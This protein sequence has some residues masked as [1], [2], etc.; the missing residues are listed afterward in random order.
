MCRTGGDLGQMNNNL[1]GRLR[2]HVTRFI[3]MNLNF[4]LPPHLILNGHKIAR[5]VFAATL[6]F[7]IRN[8]NR[9]RA[10]PVA[11]LSSVFFSQLQLR[12]KSTAPMAPVVNGHAKSSKM[13]SKVVCNK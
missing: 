6:T 13:H 3:R 2:V 10:L 4:E 1:K 8:L 9:T 11:A 5:A 7:Y 12:N